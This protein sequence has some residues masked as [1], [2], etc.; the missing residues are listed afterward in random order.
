MNIRYKLEL[1]MLGEENHILLADK[2][3]VTHLLL[4]V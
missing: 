3:L 4:K 1:L 2:Y